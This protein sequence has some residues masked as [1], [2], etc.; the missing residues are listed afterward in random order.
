NPNN[1]LALFEIGNYYFRDERN[2]S[3]AYNYLNRCVQADDSNASCYY[4][5]GRTLLDPETVIYSLEQAQQHLL[6]AHELDPDYGNIL[7]WLAETY[8]SLGQ[9]AQAL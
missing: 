5:L 9:C 8:R 6:R 7:Y 1:T 4:I 3:E 2:L